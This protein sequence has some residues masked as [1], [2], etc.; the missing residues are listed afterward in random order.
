[1]TWENNPRPQEK[2]QTKRHVRLSDVGRLTGLVGAPTQSSRAASESPALDERV[3]PYV[4]NARGPSGRRMTDASQQRFAL[5]KHDLMAGDFWRRNSRKRRARQTCD[6]THDRQGAI[7]G[8]LGAFSPGQHGLSCGVAT[9]V[10]ST[11]LACAGVT[12]EPTINPRIVS[13]AR[14]RVIPKQRGIG[15]DCQKDDEMAIWTA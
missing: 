2:R 5:W 11:I 15:Q 7:L 6:E 1:M 10:E 3:T 14:S 12:E 13:A 8:A 9:V 4:L